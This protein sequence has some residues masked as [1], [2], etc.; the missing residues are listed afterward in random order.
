[1]SE[2]LLI[3][4]WFSSMTLPFLLENIQATLYVKVPWF[5]RNSTAAI[6]LLSS[7]ITPWGL[8]LFHSRKPKIEKNFHNPLNYM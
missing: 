5:E 4:E 6:R 2:C 8:K 7:C 1:M 3:Y